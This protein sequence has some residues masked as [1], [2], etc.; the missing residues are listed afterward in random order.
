MNKR[1]EIEV[2]TKIVS[3]WNECYITQTYGML[4]GELEDNGNMQHQIHIL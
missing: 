3:A 2:S 4:A 1:L